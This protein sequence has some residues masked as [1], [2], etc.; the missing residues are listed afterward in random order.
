[1]I[2][3]SAFNNYVTN[4]Q[5]HESHLKNKTEFL[6][7]W[8]NKL[9][10]K[11]ASCKMTEDKTS[12]IVSA[13]IRLTWQSK[14]A[15][16][17]QN[18]STATV[19]CEFGSRKLGGFEDEGTFAQAPGSVQSCT[20]MQWHAADSQTPPPSLDWWALTARGLA[21][22]RGFRQKKTALIQTE[23][24]YCK[25]LLVLHVI[26]SVFV[27]AGERWMSLINYQSMHVSLWRIVGVRICGRF[28]LLFAW[29]YSYEI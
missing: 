2:L 16:P 10:S 25:C 7:I 23:V 24:H 14:R 13:C 19:S 27:C 18:Q 12:E 28:W 21:S 4:L 3:I 15:S 29:I 22:T 5:V 9:G 20:Y 6:N 11:C 26:E 8:E 1:M 17:D